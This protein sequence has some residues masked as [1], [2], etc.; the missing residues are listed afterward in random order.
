MEYSINIRDA[1][2]YILTHYAVFLW[3]ALF[4]AERLQ[5]RKVKAFLI[6][7]FWQLFFFPFMW[8]YLAKQ[9]IDY[10]LTAADIAAHSRT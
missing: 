10:F 4:L 2:P 3:A 9:C 8:V 1:Y 7:S 6:M 5:Q